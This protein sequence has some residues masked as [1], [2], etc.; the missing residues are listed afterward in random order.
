MTPESSQG[1]STSCPKKLLLAVL[2][3]TKKKKIAE[4]AKTAYHAVLETSPQRMSAFAPFFGGGG[5]G[6][7]G[8]F[9]VQARARNDNALPRK[10]ACEY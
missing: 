3:K 5:G 10:V 7:G 4:M 9:L 8:R 1:K 2:E 6:G